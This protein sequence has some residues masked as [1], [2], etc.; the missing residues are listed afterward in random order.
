MWSYSY[1]ALYHHGILG[2][3]WGVRRFRKSNGSL[4]SAGKKR[5]Q[6]LEPG[7]EQ[8]K[9]KHRLHLEDKY[10]QQGMSK[11][12]AQKAADKRIK[13]EKVLAI[14]AGVTLAAAAAYVVGSKIRDQADGIIKATS[15]LQRVEY[16]DEGTLH[17]SFY[18]AKGTRDKAKYAAFLGGTRKQQFGQAYVMEIGLKKDVKIAGQSTAKKVFREMYE[19][20]SDFRTSVEK[21]VSKHLAGGNDADPKDFSKKNMQ[22]LYENF[23]S[24]LVEMRKDGSGADKKFFD[25]LASSGYGAVQD[26]NDKK[27]SGYNANNPLIVFGSAGNATVKTFKEIT[28][29]DLQ[30][31]RLKE[32]AAEVTELLGKGAMV[33]VPYAALKTVYNDYGKKTTKNRSGGSNG[34][35]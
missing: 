33:A 18:A 7:T 3:K 31:Y 23:N 30:Q 19:N 8:K 25:R 21:S 35:R 22:R 14:T 15:T 20:D 10:K 2:M 16:S 26:I 27:F 32:G 6:N 24:S 29:G 12:D 13:I 9:S 11:T 28:E 5:Y 34:K 4:T 17:D 1:C